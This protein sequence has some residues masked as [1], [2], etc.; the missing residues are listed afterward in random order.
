MNLPFKILSTDFDGTLHTDAEHPP[1]PR[2]LQ[3]LIASLQ[4]KG[5]VWIINTGRDLPSLLES[6][7]RANMAIWP[8]YVVTVEREIYCRKN[9]SYAGMTEWN[10]KCREAHD[11][12]FNQLRADLERITA[13]VK[14]RFD[15]VI[16]EDSFSPFCLIAKNN[17]DAD[18]IQ[19][20]LDDYCRSVSDLAFV[21]NDIYARFSHVAFN[22][23]SALAEIGRQLGVSAEQIVAAG[24]HLNDLPMLSRQYAGWLIAP[25]NAVEPVKEAVKRQQGYVSEFRYGSGLVDGLERVLG[26][27][28]LRQGELNTFST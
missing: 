12:V 26:I 11:E 25:F 7:N 2:E 27:P 3:D 17:R 1:V 20:Y 28:R 4:A 16:Y 8:D 5:V 23:G 24:D 15:P 10:R 9:A 14:T 13:W 22:K 19:A 21:R 18:E 6:L